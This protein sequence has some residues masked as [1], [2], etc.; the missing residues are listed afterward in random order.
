MWSLLGRST[1]LTI[2]VAAAFCLAWACDAVYQ[3]LTGQVPNNFKFFSLFVFIIGV[4]LAGIGEIAWRPLWRR[5][6]LLQRKTFPDLGGTWKGTLI[7]TWVDPTTGSPKPPIPTDIV[8]RQ[9]LFTTSISL[10]TGESISHSTR[11]FLEPFRDTRRFRIWYSYNNDPQAQFQ[12]RSSPHEG[13]AFLECEF[14]A[15]PNRLSGRYYTARRTTGDIDVR[16][17]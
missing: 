9:G 13:V 5:F 4:V 14:D 12:H 7:S 16:R 8:I 3:L 10:K 1:Q 2:I 17:S 11:S 15:D 6:P